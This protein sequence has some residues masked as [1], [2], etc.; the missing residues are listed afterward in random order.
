MV[1]RLAQAATSPTL[2]YGKKAKYEAQAE[3]R[4]ICRLAVGQESQNWQLCEKPRTGNKVKQ[5][6][7]ATDKTQAELFNEL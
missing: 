1:F 5:Q 2:V 6:S 4:F 3:C 7:L